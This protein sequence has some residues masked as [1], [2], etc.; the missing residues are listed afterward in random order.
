MIIYYNCK[1]VQ[2]TS[3]G[4]PDKILRSKELIDR[5]RHRFTHLTLPRLVVE[6]GDNSRAYYYGHQ[7]LEDQHKKFK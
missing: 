1:L 2:V 6:Y 5:A 7:L 4:G 3:T